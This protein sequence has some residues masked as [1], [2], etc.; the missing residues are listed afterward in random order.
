M[1][2]RPPR[3]TL[4]PYTTLFRSPRGQRPRAPW[5]GHAGPALLPRSGSRAGLAAA[6][7]RAAP[8]GVLTRPPTG[9]RAPAA[10]AAARRPDV[11]RVSGAAGVERRGLR[12]DADRAPDRAGPEHRRDH[13]DRQPHRAEA[14]RR[15]GLRPGPDAG[16]QRAGGAAPRHAARAE[17]VGDAPGRTGGARAPPPRV[18]ERRRPRRHR[19]PARRPGGRTAALSRAR[20]ETA[21][22][23]AAAASAFLKSAS[24][25][26]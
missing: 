21:Q 10:R 22:A 16:E 11:G 7:P 9:P 24:V 26:P 20:A 14:P 2:R 4:F 3:S 1:I 15:G 8:H 17:G 19:A 23:R 13:P 25:K 5:R 12:A 18:P 6:P